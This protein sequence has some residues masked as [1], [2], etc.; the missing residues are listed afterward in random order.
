MNLT[1]WA[2]FF[3]DFFLKDHYKI[4]HKKKKEFNTNL[5]INTNSTEYR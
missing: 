3:I 2:L 4:D 1:K 5:F